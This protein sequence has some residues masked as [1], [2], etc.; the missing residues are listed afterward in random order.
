MN[1]ANISDVSLLMASS[2]VLVS[3]LF[4][5]FQKLRLEKETLISVIRAVIQLFAVGYVLQ[6]IF[7]LRNPAVTT[8]IV[9]FMTFN[10]A[11]NAAKR[12][13]GIKNGILISFLS[14]LVGAGATLSVLVLSGAVRYEANQIIPI[15]GMIISN[16]MVAIG[17]CY[18]QL[19]G[20]FKSRRNEVEIKLSL[21][22][23][24][25]P[26]SMDILRDSIRTGMVPTID[27]TKTLGIVSL[28]GMMSG[29][30]LAGTSPLMAIRY[31]I[32][33][34]FMLLSTTAISSFMACFLSYRTFFNERK[35]LL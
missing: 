32:M 5:Y 21:G 25:L 18:R 19:T 7:R 12:G 24:L 8:L 16:A 20:D 35:Q 14:I 29:L 28:P 26:A 10:A 30:I 15:S 3:L 17:L 4:S 6:F 23:D 31:Q 33:V 9:L 22:A 11:F 27:S 1:G 34:T 13:K 2:L